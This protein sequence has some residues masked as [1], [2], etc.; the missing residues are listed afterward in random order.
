MTALCLKRQIEGNLLS[1]S[2]HSLASLK[3][4][5]MVSFRSSGFTKVFHNS[6]I[7][8]PLGSPKNHTNFYHLKKPFHYISLFHLRTP[9]ERDIPLFLS[10]PPARSSRRTA[11]RFSLR[12]LLTEIYSCESLADLTCISNTL[13]HSHAASKCPA[14]ILRAAQFHQQMHLTEPG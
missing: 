2:L 7:E 3:S 6:A 13:A 5:N 9:D 4:H 1:I 8:E 14:A 11:L 12:T 10:I